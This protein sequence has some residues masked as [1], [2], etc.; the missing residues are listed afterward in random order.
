MN[1]FVKKLEIGVQI[2]GSPYVSWRSLPSRLASARRLTTTNYS[3][4]VVLTMN[5]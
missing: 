1:L 4:L 3:L 5:E 2:Q